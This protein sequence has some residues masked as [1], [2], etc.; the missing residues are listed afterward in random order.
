MHYVLKEVKEEVPWTE[1][2]IRNS[3]FVKDRL[4]KRLDRKELNSSNQQ[5]PSI[6]DGRRIARVDQGHAFVPPFSRKADGIYFLR[7]GNTP[8]VVREVNPSLTSASFQKQLGASQR[9]KEGLG[10]KH[11]KLIGECHVENMHLLVPSEEVLLVF[12]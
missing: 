9:Y 5:P 8:F 4:E 7:H 1:D 11:V 12:Y 2:N 3:S 10:V 6:V